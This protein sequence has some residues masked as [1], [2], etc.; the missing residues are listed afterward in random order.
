MFTPHRHLTY[1]RSMNRPLSDREKTCP[2][3]LRVFCSNHRHN[4]MSEYMR[5][6]EIGNNFEAFSKYSIFSGKYLEGLRAVAVPK[7][8][9]PSTQLKSISTFSN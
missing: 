9:V 6:N 7:R 1:G 5:G 8:S 4:N 2:L 3:L